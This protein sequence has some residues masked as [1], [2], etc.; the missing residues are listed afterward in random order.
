ML[1]SSLKASDFLIFKFLF[2]HSKSL[3]FFRNFRRKMDSPTTTLGWLVLFQIFNLMR[4]GVQAWFLKSLDHRYWRDQA[5]P[6]FCLKTL[7]WKKSYDESG[8]VSLTA[9]E[10]VVSDRN[11]Q[12]DFFGDQRDRIFIRYITTVFYFPGN[13]T[14]GCKNQWDGFNPPPPFDLENCRRYESVRHFLRCGDLVPDSPRVQG[15]SVQSWFGMKN[16]QR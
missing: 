5:P 12:V 3:F 8:R 10:L 14:K 4:I 9:A 16:G 13:H 15:H 7:N 2:F 1:F 11:W 6:E